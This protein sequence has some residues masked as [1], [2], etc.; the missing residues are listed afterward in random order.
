MNKEK[1]SVLAEEVGLLNYPTLLSHIE[2]YSII[3]RFANLISD[4]ARAEE[5]ERCLKACLSV[6]IPVTMFDGRPCDDADAAIRAIAAAISSDEAN[7][8]EA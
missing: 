5:R 2:H 4:A 1:I 3:E 6:K 7:E 8:G